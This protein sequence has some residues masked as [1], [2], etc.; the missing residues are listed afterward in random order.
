MLVLGRK[1]GQRIIITTG[2]E[3]IEVVVCDIER[4]RVKVGVDAPRRVLIHRE[5][6]CDR[7]SLNKTERVSH[8]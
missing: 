7:I 2:T 4:D 5:E 3:R 1:E 6:V 8:D